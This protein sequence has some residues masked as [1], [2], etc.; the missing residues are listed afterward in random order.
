[1][2]LQWGEA[3]HH[4]KAMLSAYVVE[5]SEATNGGGE[6]FYQV[7]K[8]DQD[9]RQWLASGLVPATT[10][11]FRVAASSVRGGLGHFSPA[12]TVTTSALPEN[13]WRRVWPHRPAVAGAGGGQALV[14]TPTAQGRA[15][16]VTPPP[17]AAR[18]L[19]AASARIRARRLGQPTAP[20]PY[21]PLHSLAASSRPPPPPSASAPSGRP[22]VAATAL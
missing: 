21:T 8:G 1:M 20:S 17:R 11:R 9:T 15:W 6:G 3:R 13:V 10:Y 4:P 2:L 12:L 22:R 16:P 18:R 14:D 5:M 7:Y 19:R